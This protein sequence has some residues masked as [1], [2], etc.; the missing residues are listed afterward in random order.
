MAV[1]LNSEDVLPAVIG[2]SRVLSLFSEEELPSTVNFSQTED[3]QDTLCDLLK[4]LIWY[5]YIP[6]TNETNY[7]T[8]AAGAPTSKNLKREPKKIA[9]KIFRSL[10]NDI[11][12]VL[13]HMK[14]GR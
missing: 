2:L 6:N 9:G 7:I 13:G 3:G 11:L 14:F 10:F 1:P 12:Y 4:D 8:A 5:C